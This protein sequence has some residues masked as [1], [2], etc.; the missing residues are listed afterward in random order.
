M[1]ERQATPQASL[2]DRMDALAASHPR[3][4]ELRLKAADLREG[5]N[6]FCAVPQTVSAQS[7]MGRWAR[8]RRLWCEVTGEPLI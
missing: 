4:D 3:G 8:A 7:F 2:A 5:A 6:G 1:S